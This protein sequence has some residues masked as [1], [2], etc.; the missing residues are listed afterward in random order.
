[1]NLLPRALLLQVLLS[2][3][4]EVI[5]QLIGQVAQVHKPSLGEPCIAFERRNLSQR[6]TH[7]FKNKQKQKQKTL[8]TRPSRTAWRCGAILDLVHQLRSLL[9]RSAHLP[10]RGALALTSQ[11]GMSSQK[12]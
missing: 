9:L 10:K 11:Q 12:E 2:D 8:I 5:D 6:R 4:V 3:C 7:R 1:V